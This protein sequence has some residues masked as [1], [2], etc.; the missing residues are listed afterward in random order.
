[1]TTSVV[2]PYRQHDFPV[3]TT[4]LDECE[5]LHSPCELGHISLEQGHDCS[6]LGR[7][8]LYRGKCGPLV[9]FCGEGVLVALYVSKCSPPLVCFLCKRVLE[10]LY[11]GEV[12]LC[13]RCGGLAAPTFCSRLRQ[14]FPPGGCRLSELFSN[15]RLGLSVPLVSL[16]CNGIRPRG[17]RLSMLLLR[18]QRTCAE[19]LLVLLHAGK[20]G[21]TLQ[22]PQDLASKPGKEA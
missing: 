21:L 14:H 6:K 19:N 11:L 20:C 1:M 13:G 9:L 7:L 18:L 8:L 2:G 12:E 22:S 15:R 5:G 4:L 3:V 10:A 17:S 16:I